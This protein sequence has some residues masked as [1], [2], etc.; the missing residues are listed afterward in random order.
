[1]T[2]APDRSAQPPLIPAHLPRKL[3]IDL[4]IWSWI[5]AAT[6]GEPY[7]DLE[8]CVLETKARGFNAVRIEAGL[9]WAFTLD[10]RPRGPVSF[11]P[12]IAGYSS[13]A[14]SADARGGGRHDILERVLHLFEL[15]RRHDLYVILTSWEYQDSSWFVAEP[16]LRAEVFAIPPEHRFRHLAEQ[17]DRLLNLLKA[18][19]LAAHVAFVE[20]HN[21]PDCSDLPQGA[22]GKR[23]HTEAIALLRARHSDILVSGDFAGHDYALVPDNV[24]VFDQHV[25]AAVGWYFEHIYKQTVLSKEFDPRQPRALEPLRRILKDEIVPWDVFIGPARNVKPFWHPM[26]WLYENI[27]N[28]RWDGW[29]TEMFPQWKDRIW[30]EAR[31][32]FAEDAQE[33]GRRGL[34]L[35]FDEGG[36]FAPP[37]L[38]QFELTPAGLSL[39]ELFA[40]LAIAHNYW[41]FMP[42]TF[43]SPDHLIWH[44]NPEWLRRINAR[45]QSGSLQ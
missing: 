44:Q 15:A 26:M 27:D 24:Q 19:G 12:W 28:A 43:C 23:L 41:G 17:H 34:P 18:R 36:Y 30:A 39:F 1:M 45:F 11:G 33:A 14:A 4:W 22:D 13:N 9:N 3:S 25:Y 37:R 7:D 32:R 6:P 29:V 42:W 5:S 31:K 16:A 2:V 20:I 35:V 38:S 40:D 8:R 10:G 21:E